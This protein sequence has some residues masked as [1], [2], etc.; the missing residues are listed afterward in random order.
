MKGR[1]MPKIV[2]DRSGNLRKSIFYRF[3]VPFWDNA[4]DLDPTPDWIV[5]PRTPSNDELERRGHPMYMWIAITSGWESRVET[6]DCPT[7]PTHVAHRYFTKNAGEAFG[8]TRVAAFVPTD[9]TNDLTV[10]KDIHNRITQLSLRGA[11]L[12]P[13]NLKDHHSGRRI[14]GYWTLQ[15]VG[16]A[17]RRLPK[18]VDASNRCP[19]CGIGIIGCEDCGQWNPYCSACKKEVAIWHTKHEGPGDKRLPI[20][21]DPWRVIEGKTW[22]GSDLV[23]AGGWNFASKR[24]VDWLLRIHAAPFYAEPVWFCV[25]GM[26]DQQ[27]K[28]FDDLQKPFEA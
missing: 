6:K 18:I 25:D 27:K 13:L 26:N 10:T 21:E 2:L 9:T 19:H 20:E 15:F 28:W 17:R 14:D 12:D 4:E 7:D 23:Q 5:V 22:D 11:R 8:G 1:S 16:R 24:F 3:G